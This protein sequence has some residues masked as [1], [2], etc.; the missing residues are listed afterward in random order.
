MVELYINNERVIIVYADE[1][2]VE[3]FY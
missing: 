1:K 2:Y 3:K